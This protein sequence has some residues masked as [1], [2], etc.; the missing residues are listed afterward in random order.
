MENKR[1]CE[2]NKYHKVASCSF[3]K[4]KKEMHFFPFLLFPSIFFLLFFPLGHG[5]V[6]GSSTK[7]FIFSLRNHEGLGPFMSKARYPGRHSVGMFPGFGQTFGHGHDI[8][9]ADNAN[10]NTKSY[11]NFSY[12][13]DFLVPSAVQD[14]KTVLA[15]TYHFTP[16]EVEVF[17]LGWF[18]RWLDCYVSIFNEVCISF[19][20]ID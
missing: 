14:S 12:H 13:K 10:N 4:K 11:T 8:Y 20:L 3:G 2:K 19:M 1:E 9:I 16:D 18:V 15:G 6:Y 7:A 17:Y 5:G